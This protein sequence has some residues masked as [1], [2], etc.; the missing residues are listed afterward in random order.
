M[1]VYGVVLGGWASNNKYA[2]YGSMRAA[3]QMLS[4]EIP[5][6]LGIL[7]IVLT[8]GHLRL[9]DIVTAQANGVWYVL[10][11]P[12]AFVMVFITALAETNRTPFDL[13]EAEQELVGGFHTE[14]SAMK[15]AMFFLAEYMH[16]ITVSA[17]MVALFFG[18]YSLP[19]VAWCRPED[20]SL[21]G[22]LAKITVFSA[23]IAAF[24]FLFM[25]I[26]WTLP[27]FRFDQLM[28]LAWKGLVPLGL[29]LVA[30]TCTLVYFGAPESFWAPF[31]N[32][33]IL[34]L[35]WIGQDQSRSL[36]TGRQSAIRPVPLDRFA[37]DVKS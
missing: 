18:G 20:M 22:V 6:G 34:V 31:G 4:Y 30:W 11:H 1:G 24:I 5:M 33:V 12:L 28:R 36:I 9:E 29:G 19:G 10:L 35:V 17:F 21:F 7:V 37:T 32:V 25:W 27:R 13:A 8:C 16:I 2:F 23:K 15:F 3:A 14:Y 26:R